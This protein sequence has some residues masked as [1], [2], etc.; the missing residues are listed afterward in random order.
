MIDSVTVAAPQLKA[1]TLRALAVTSK[2][3]WPLLQGAPSAHDTLPGYEVMS[4][5]GLAGP[6][7]MPQDV[8]E[9]LNQAVKTVLSDPEIV[10]SLNSM[11]SDAWYSK[12]E[13]MRDMIATTIKQ[14]KHVVETA[15][16]PLQ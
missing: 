10:T 3:P 8:V 12:P 16:I 1:G 7:D 4:W 13:D 11:G 9:R 6:A 2:Q 5:L 14:W 15:N